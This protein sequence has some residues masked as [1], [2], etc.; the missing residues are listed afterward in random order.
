M[1]EEYCLTF[2]RAESNFYIRHSFDRTRCDP[3]FLDIVNK[4]WSRRNNDNYKV[5]H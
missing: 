5:D 1:H 2:I 3:P 4:R